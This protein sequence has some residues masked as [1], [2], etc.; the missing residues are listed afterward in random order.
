MPNSLAHSSLGGLPL[1]PTGAKGSTFPRAGT[2]MIGSALLV[3][4]RLH[5][6]AI[7]LPAGT[8]LTSITFVSS[9][10]AAGTP[11]NQ[12]FALYS[13]ALALLRQTVD[14]GTAAWA[15]STAK[16]LALTSGFT[17]TA[18]GLHYLGVMVNAT[19]APSLAACSGL[20]QVHALAPVT[21]GF[22]T[23]GLTDTAPNPAAAPAGQANAPWAFVS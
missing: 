9:T 12:W 16:T 7:D 15:V 14:D 1:R 13:S 4:G 19:T 2:P 3:S 18:T 8:P 5:L 22:S 23:T 17:T 20:A 10:V 11:L 6:V 21:N